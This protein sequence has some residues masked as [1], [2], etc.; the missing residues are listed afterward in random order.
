MKLLHALTAVLALALPVA[1]AA[2]WQWIDKDGRKVFSDQAPPSDIPAKNILKQPPG[3]AAAAPAPVPGD[4]AAVSQPDGGKAVAA[5]PPKPTASAPRLSGKDKELEEKKKQAEAAEAASKKAA[6]E[7]VAKVRAEN[8]ERVKKA[9]ASMDSGVRIA[10]TNAKGER[11]YMS[12][13]ARA[14]ESKRLGEV[15]AAECGAA[16]KL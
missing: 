2:Q 9:K 3:R 6:E 16:P 11:E 4:A 1:A 7:R 10:T 8:C 13:A 15:A 12:D 5:T 14:A